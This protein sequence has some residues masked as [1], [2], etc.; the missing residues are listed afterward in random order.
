V[1]EITNQMFINRDGKHMTRCWGFG[2]IERDGKTKRVPI[3][4]EVPTDPD[5][6]KRK[7]TVMEAQPLI[8]PSDNRRETVGVTSGWKRN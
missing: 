8:P 1:P 3:M 2:N 6:I 5:S 7:Q 4:Y